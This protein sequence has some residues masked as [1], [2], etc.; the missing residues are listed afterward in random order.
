MYQK[1]TI[2]IYKKNSYN[3]K[4]AIL[5]QH[6]VAILLNSYGLSL[7]KIIQK[8]YVLKIIKNQQNKGLRLHYKNPSIYYIQFF[9]VTFL[10]RI[11]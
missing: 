9:I 3:Q 4:N 2:K 1:I 5:N 10:Y 11:L 7:N 6:Y 8:I